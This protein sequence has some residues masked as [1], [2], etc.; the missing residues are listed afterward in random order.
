MR[1][2]RDTA[3]SEAAIARQRS[4]E[5]S[6]TRTIPLPAPSRS[7]SP[8]SSASLSPRTPT[9]PLTLS[10]QVHIAYADDDIHLA[11]VLLLR[12]QGIEVDSDDDPRIAAVRDEDFD[13]CFIPFGRLDDGRGEP[14]TSNISKAPPDPHRADARRADALREKERLWE[15][16]ARRYAE[17]RNRCAVLK[18]R[19]FDTLRVASIEHERLRL[20]K[21]KEAAAAAVDLRRRRMQ[22]TSRTLN[23]SLVPPVPQPPPRFTYDFP[24]TPRNSTPRAVPP[25][26]PPR[27]SPQRRQ[28][29]EE[30]VE[31]R[32]PTRVTFPEVLACM[33]GALFPELPGERTLSTS[34]DRT[35]ARRQRVL[36]DA[37]LTH[38]ADISSA[39]KGKGKAPTE[40][41]RC[42]VCRP[43]PRTPSPLPSPSSSGLS[44]AGS[45]LSFG[46]GSSSSRTS[47]LSTASTSTAASSVA[48]D[49]PPLPKAQAPLRLWLPGARRTASPSPTPSSSA[50][51]CSCPRPCA[52]QPVSTH[53]LL[54]PA[55]DPPA[56]PPRR[57]FPPH[58]SSSTPSHANYTHTDAD[59]GGA[60]PFTLALGRLVALARNLQASYVRAVVVGY[61]GVSTEWGEEDQDQDAYSLPRESESEKSAPPPPPPPKRV[62][63][64][65]MASK[66]RVRPA[67][68]RASKAD[69]CAFLS[70]SASMS[71]S[72]SASQSSS[73]ANA[74]DED[75]LVPVACLTPLAPYPHS[76]TDAHSRPRTQ[77][78]ARLPY[79]LVFA[80][81]PP[82]PRSPWAPAPA[83][84]GAR[85][86]T[87]GP[88]PCSVEAVRAKAKAQ[89]VR[90][91]PR[92]DATSDA[93]TADCGGEDSE[94]DD[95]DAHWTR[96]RGPVLR[97]RAVPNSAFLRLKAL[98]NH[99]LVR[100]YAYDALRDGDIHGTGN[101]LPT[102]PPPAPRRPREC[103]VGLGVD[104][105]PGSGLRF[106]Y[107]N[108]RG[109]VG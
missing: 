10:D 108:A 92:A 65:A 106:V 33:H 26:S 47:T 98:H 59:G 11:K 100:G 41:R 51:V 3:V 62:R 68:V 58:M 50:A 90:R 5:R 25:P 49:S 43:R 28:E 70:A 84:V 24:F 32:E 35:K 81:P 87:A 96:T 80:P 17:E 16:E 76:L 54:Q 66:L 95:D 36:L 75:P 73:L 12:L 34:A 85:P 74:E 64:P 86:P 107:A 53:P 29:P 67:G 9:P 88:V 82:L 102:P 7:P 6:R 8:P 105:P 48:P 38:A 101:G 1:R 19:E 14:S 22:P 40:P 78:P 79:A 94:D 71:P 13:A 56:F 99:T 20:I 2:G 83:S 18:R 93:E 23:F 61:G 37:L 91:A 15:T 63:V 27:H 44:R 109:V 21:Q 103:V 97:A 104:R 46:G 57:R 77:L 60:L 4:E 69:V 52:R 55:L 45:W 89:M 31:K 39:R 42:L 30:D 72:P